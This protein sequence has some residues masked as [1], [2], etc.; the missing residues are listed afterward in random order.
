[1]A[2]QADQPEWRCV[3]ARR[4]R[5]CVARE[6][7][8]IGRFADALENDLAIAGVIPAARLSLATVLDELL[9]NVVMHAQTVRGPVHVRLRRRNGEL[10]ARLRYFATAFDPTAHPPPQQ[11]ATI[12][13][14]RTGG[15]GIAMVRAM[16]REFA[17][18]HA[19]GE[20][21]LCV[22]I[23]EQGLGARKAGARD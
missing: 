3:A 2:D 21:H 23:E 5:Y 22:R 16:T 8:A 18:W 10:V 13:E 12:G 14:A 6:R 7:A 15:V 1:M 19:R 20:N 17:W 4:W 11:P 9:A